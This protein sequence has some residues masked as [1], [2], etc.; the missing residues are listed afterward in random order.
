MWDKQEKRGQTRAAQIFQEVAPLLRS[1]DLLGFIFLTVHYQNP[2]ERDYEIEKE[3]FQFPHL[4]DVKEI[5]EK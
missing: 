5:K 2:G 4:Q 1:R 3:I